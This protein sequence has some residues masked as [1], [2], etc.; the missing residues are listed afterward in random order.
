MI[1]YALGHAINV[2]LTVAALQAALQTRRPPAGCIHH[3]D[4]GSQY[5]A[6]AYR[7]LLQAHGLVGSM[8][9]RGDSLR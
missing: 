4:R 3:S 9:R 7:K 6:A 2:R 8:G 5:A 1:G